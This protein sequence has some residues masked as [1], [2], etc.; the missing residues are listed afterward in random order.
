MKAFPALL[1]ILV[2]AGFVSSSPAQTQNTLPPVYIVPNF[3]PASCGWL[4]NWSVERNYCANSY[5]RHLDRVR[6]DANYN[7]V[8][9]ECNNMI[10]IQ[11]FV[12]ER[13]GELKKRVKEG[14]VELVN[15][16]FLEP[17]VSLSGGE[18]L[19]K[20]GVEGLRWQQQVMGMRPRFCWAIDTCGIHEQMPQIVAKLGLE[21]LV[22]CRNNPAGKTLFYSE[23]PDGSRIPTLVTEQYSDWSKDGVSMVFAEKNPFTQQQLKDLESYFAKKTPSTPKGAPILVL[24][25]KGDYSLPPA[26][27]ENP[28]ELL[29]LWKTFAPDVLLKLSTLSDY[30]DKLSLDKLDLRTVRS[31]T[32][33]T[34]SAFW[35]Q[36]H[37]VK[38]WYRRDEHAL[39]AAET[40]A[41]IAS[42]KAGYGY[43][44]ELLNHAW[45]LMLL[46]MDRNTLWGAAGGM[47]FEDADSW[48]AKDRFEWVETNAARVTSEASRKLTGGDGATLLFNPLNWERHDPVD[49]SYEAS[50][51][52]VGIGPAAISVEAKEIALPE[53]IDTKF[54]SARFD[55]KTGAIVS[56]KL[57]PSGREVLGGSANVLV[58]EKGLTGH[59]EAG[60]NLF[61]RAQRPR[62]AT[63]GDSRIDN[64]RDGKCGGDLGR[65]H[66]QAAWRHSLPPGGALQQELSA[67]R[68]RGRVERH[69][70]PYRGARRV[71]ACRSTDGNQAR[72]PVWL[73]ARCLA[74]THGGASRLDLRH[75]ACGAL[76]RLHAA[77]W[78]R[79]RAA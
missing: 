33:Y 31:G 63:S 67:H 20:M 69:P 70:R 11:N 37:R 64:A 41:T 16:F 73:L 62:I 23:S 3:H 5:L 25:G 57:K 38:S 79:H 1:T 66:R 43:P 39:Q 74:E 46:N 42:L 60:D 14:R 72:H 49:G 77:G 17:T 32:R 29:G 78:R 54:Y 24:G 68:L 45:L 48:D 19:A 40:M 58:A 47:V 56:L 65:D 18:A 59:S 21:A 75:P 28:T 9:S 44:A 76:E 51:P 55:A 7:F 15:A 35:V 2:A 4:A 10:A 27:K 30:Y 34:W 22:Y 61:E 13:F 26:R 52:S 50:L 53:T 36:N 71:S 6:D 12:P 8:L